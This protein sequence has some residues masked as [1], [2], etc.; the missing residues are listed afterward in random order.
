MLK[1]KTERV[2]RGWVI[3]GLLASILRDVEGQVVVELPNQVATNFVTATI[4][5]PGAE[6]MAVQMQ[7]VDSSTSPFQFGRGLM[8]EPPPIKPGDWMPVQDSLRIE[9]GDGDGLRA[10]SVTFR[11]PKNGRIRE[12]SVVKVVTA[13]VTIVITEPV[14][15]VRIHSLLQVKGQTMGATETFTYTL[16]DATGQVQT[17]DVLFTLLQTDLRSI[18]PSGGRFH[19][20]DLRLA[21]GTNTLS[22][23]AVTPGGQVTLTNLELVLDHSLMTNAPVISLAFPL[24]G[25]ELSGPSFTARGMLD[26]PTA[27][28]TARV[29]AAGG[30]EE[31]HAL[32]GRDGDFYVEE[33]P[34]F[35]GTNQLEIVATNA[36]GLVSRTNLVFH[37]SPIDLVIDRI[38]EESLDR[39]VLTLTGSISV[40]NHTVWVNGHKATMLPAGRWAVSNY[41]VPINAGLNF[42][43]VAVPNSNNGGYGTF[44]R[45][46]P[47]DDSPPEPLALAAA[48]GVNVRELLQHS[49]LIRSNLLA[50]R[51]PAAGRRSPVATGSIDY[52]AWLIEH[53]IFI[54]S[55]GLVMLVILGTFGFRLRQRRKR[56][57]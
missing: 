33:L 41:H 20:P 4:H 9:L 51:P 55:T 3:L 28:V 54:Y 2:A 49:E 30:A 31:L 19:I 12:T 25:A 18:T 50:H 53:R 15:R 1:H 45:D 13:P 7:R 5:A 34:I 36:R 42:E 57:S 14:N 16:T 17:D 37:R 6:A 22:L 27:A 44:S 35:E 29:I 24:P 11:M 39:S 46:R 32:V 48:V 47:S 10:I 21:E 40:T 8:T 23:R 56:P 26:D 43:A 38:P 52:L